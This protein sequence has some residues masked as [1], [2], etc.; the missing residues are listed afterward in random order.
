MKELLKKIYDETPISRRKYKLSSEDNDIII[1]F[2]EG[3]KVEILGDVEKEYEIYFIDSDLNKTIYHTKIKTNMWSAP[4]L[5]YFV[6]WKVEIKCEGNLIITQTLNLKSKRVKIVCDTNSMGDLLAFIGAIDAFQRKHL[7]EIHCVVFNSHI[8]KIFEESYEN[9]KFLGTN[10]ADSSYY[11][12]YKIGYFF[13]WNEGWAKQ[14]PRTISLAKIAPSILG[15]EEKEYKPKLKFNTEKLLNKKYVCIG[16]QSTA[17][18]KYW[19]NSTGWNDVVEY[20]NSIGYEV[21]CID[22]SSS[23]GSGNYMNYMPSGVVDKTGN[24][25]L[26]ERMQQLAGAEFFIGIGSGLSWLAWSVGVPVIMISGFSKSFAEFE[27]P[28]RII[29]EKVCNGCWNDT[30]EV[31][32]K[33]KWGWCP[34]NKNF[35]CTEKISSS[36]VINCID[37]LVK[38]DTITIITSHAN[39]EKK[40]DILIECINS[41]KNNAHTKI[42][43]SSNATVPENIQNLCDYVVYTKENPILAESEYSKYDLKYYI[44]SGLGD[45]VVHKKVPYDYGYSVYVM[46]QNAINLANNL[47]YKRVH[48]LDYDYE[49]NDTIFLEHS[50]LLN[51]YDCVFYKWPKNNYGY[52]AYVAAFFSAKTEEVLKIL[53]TYKSKNEYYSE[54]KLTRL[55][56]IETQFYYLANKLNLKLIEIDENI[57]KSSVLSNKMVNFSF[58]E[59]LRIWSFDRTNNKLSFILNK[60]L[61]SAVLILKE[62][63][64]KQQCYRWE[65]QEFKKDVGYFIIP[66]NSSKLTNENFSGFILD[67]YENDVFI[68]SQEINIVPDIKTENVHQIETNKIEYVGTTENQ[69]GIN[70]KLVSDQNCDVNVKIIDSFTGFVFFSQDMT[71]N[72]RPVYYTTHAYKLPN[73]IFRIFEKHSGKLLLEKTL[74]ENLEYDPKIFPQ[75]NKNLSDRITGKMKHSPI[76]GHSYFE[77]YRLNAYNVGKC[78][79][80]KDDIV[81]DLGANC[82]LFS[83]YC[84]LNGAKKVYSFEPT[85]ELK[86]C[87]EQMNV[88]FDYVY[89]PKAVYS[90]PVKL[91]KHEN[92]LQSHVEESETDDSGGFINLNEFINSNK[93]DKIDYLKVDIEGS[94]YDFFK[95]IDKNYLKN[96]VRKLALEFHNNKE[97]KVSEI[98]DV[99]NECGFS[100]QFERENGIDL[101]LGMLYAV[102]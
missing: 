20:L 97:R 55:N 60:N 42:I 66:V 50:K 87:F 41:V 68:E 54:K 10:N 51:E 37:R 98:L 49:I 15:L 76:F 19:N 53:N 38:N 22:K 43:L 74:N 85:P 95:T 12:Q 14:D 28:Y 63:T 48:V 31:F 25:S 8:K 83:R 93:I 39:T 89:T 11:A 99:L 58:P 18:C 26:E 62:K 100:I 30:S 3:V 45:K 16:I 80:E 27:T 88:G 21:W 7:A 82:G 91:I 23:F 78:K 9:I 34:R 32:D 65:S 79:I 86:E 29:N 57:L 2:I 46:L 71:L 75:E 101:E 40:R 90:K 81:F 5:R 61:Y 24:I 1:S 84:F 52:D 73:Q 72:N 47:G 64:T 56:V 36:T 4:S 92:P 59:L 96:N 13:S 70:Y 102:K 69:L 44:W 6:N 67:V 35:E 17:Q 77:L 94:E 33:S